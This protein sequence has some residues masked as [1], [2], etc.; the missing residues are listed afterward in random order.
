MSFMV[1]WFVHDHMTSAINENVNI[2]QFGLRGSTCGTLECRAKDAR[3]RTPNF[4]QE[5]TLHTINIC[6][7]MKMM[8]TRG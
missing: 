5:Y 4:H 3:K 1:P 8:M 2:K 6:T 7:M